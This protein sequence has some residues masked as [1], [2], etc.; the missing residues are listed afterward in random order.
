MTRVDEAADVFLQWEKLGKP[1]LCSPKLYT[2]LG[3]L[4]GENPKWGGE[5]PAVPVKNHGVLFSL[6]TFAQVLYLSAS[7]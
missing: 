2:A 4:L 3:F 6:L 5:G 1:T 7:P